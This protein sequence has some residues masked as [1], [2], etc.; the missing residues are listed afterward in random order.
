MSLKEK[1]E[2]FPDANKPQSKYEDERFG[3]MTVNKARQQQKR[4]LV[5][6]NMIRNGEGK[7]AMGMVVTPEEE[8]LMNNRHLFL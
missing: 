2:I 8:W 4:E 5:L 7:K 6:N 1:K 3:G